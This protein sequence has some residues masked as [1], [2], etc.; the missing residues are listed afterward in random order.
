[1]PA[2]SDMATGDAAGSYTAA[3]DQIPADGDD[4]RPRLRSLSPSRASDFKQCPQLFKFRVIDRLPEPVS[5]HQAR[6]TAAHLALER[7]YERPAPER[8]AEALYD[9]FRGAWSELRS[10]E[11][12]A[13]LFADADEERAWGLASLDLLRN[14]FSIEDPTSVDPLERELDLT[15]E[16]EGMVIRGILDRID[17][18]PDGDLV[19]LDYKTGRAPPERYAASAFFAMKIYAVLIRRRLGRTPAE[20]RLIYLNGPTQY[21][22]PVNDRVLDGVER[23]VRALWTSIESAIESGTYRP[24]P[25]VLCD[26]CSFQDRCPAFAE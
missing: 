24:S 17:E 14:Y 25:S 22:M 5:V 19:I 15:E 26:W 23:Q 13:D 2:T 7:L 11:T 12:Y 3:N 9:L 4:G 10:D 6:G 20:L 18:T 1:M 8:T 21:T 16:L